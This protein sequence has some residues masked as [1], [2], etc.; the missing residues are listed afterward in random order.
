MV[1][2]LDKKLKLGTCTTKPRT[3]TSNCLDCNNCFK[4]KCDSSRKKKE[5]GFSDG[6]MT[7]ARKNNLTLQ[8]FMMQHAT[9]SCER[10]T[11]QQCQ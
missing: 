4:T 8:L 1:M 9:N 3:S 7:S 10:W 2:I 5:E 11:R 6:R